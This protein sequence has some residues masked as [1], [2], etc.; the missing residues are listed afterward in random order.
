MPFDGEEA[1]IVVNTVLP[2]TAD[3]TEG[4]KTLGPVLRR[5]C[6]FIEGGSQCVCVWGSRSYD[7]CHQRGCRGYTP[8]RELIEHG[9]G[10]AIVDTMALRLAIM[11][12][13][14]APAMA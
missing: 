2:L 1:V 12:D 4:D 6:C 11:E 14:I 7:L 8:T 9:I 3:L 13:V 5:K 10:A